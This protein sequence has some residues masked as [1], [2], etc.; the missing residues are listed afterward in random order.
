MKD[1]A[2]ALLKEA[3]K[4][5]GEANE[6]LCR[7]HEDVVSVLVCKK[8][9]RATENFLRGFLLKNKV[10]PGIEK[11]LDELLEQCLCINPNF[12][13]V[14]LSQFDCRSVKLDSRQC[15][16]VSKVSSCFINASNLETFLRDEKVI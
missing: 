13:N 16:E 10:E 4:K 1:R 9:Q 11:S 6:E 5:L 7:P 15:N 3:V 8:A 12:K 14:D 2:E